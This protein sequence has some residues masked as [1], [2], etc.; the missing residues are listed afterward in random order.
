MGDLQSIKEMSETVFYI[1]NGGHDWLRSV[2]T[3]GFPIV[4]D[5]CEFDSPYIL[6]K[7][8]HECP[9]SVEDLETISTSPWSLQFACFRASAKIMRWPDDSVTTEGIRKHE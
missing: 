3:Y 1:F 7:G 9:P 5:L 8:P 4:T 6:S 2:A